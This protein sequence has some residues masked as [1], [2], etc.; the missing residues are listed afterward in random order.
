MARTCYSE[1]GGEEMVINSQSRAKVSGLPVFPWETSGK[2]SPVYLLYGEEQYLIKQALNSL[3]NCFL[4]D[5]DEWNFEL[6]DGKE[7]SSEEIVNAANTVPFWG[8]RKMVVVK[9]TSLFQSR[10][11]QEETGETEL[12]A[13]NHRLLAYLADPNPQTCLVLV[14]LGKVDTRR[15]VYKAVEKSGLV[16]EFAPLKGKALQDWLHREAASRGKTFDNQALDYLIACGGNN[17]SLLAAEIAKISD[18]LGEESRITLPVV[19]SITGVTQEAGIFQLVDAVAE[20]RIGQGIRLLREM[21]TLGEQPVPIALM[22][23]RQF[24]LML[25]AKSAKAENLA[26]ILQVHP[27]VAQ[28]AVAQAKNFSHQQLKK[29]LQD[30]LRLDV[31]LKSGKGPPHLLLEM[32]LLRL[33]IDREKQ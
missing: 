24:R 13:Q 33:V 8:D 25:A 29:I 10:P 32:A 2:M 22:L 26:S 30:F 27:Y 12:G 5:T 16:M 11:S 7:I 15:K 17:L 20:K 14:A 23:A 19:Q 21:F 18:Y 9:N 3:R 1:V 4:P 6:L 28:K 31:A